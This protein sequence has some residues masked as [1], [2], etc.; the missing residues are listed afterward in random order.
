L[1]VNEAF[2]RKFLPGRDP[3]GAVVPFDRGR[4]VPVEKTIVGVVADAVYHSVRRIDE[5]TE[6]APLAQL[7]FPI[8][9]AVDAIISVRA[10][11]GSPLLLVRS[12][13]AA[14]G[15][16]SRDLVFAFRPLSEQ[17]VHR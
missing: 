9:P 14:L 11:N 5:P 1:I 8:P 10:A 4:G 13:A 7:D 16:A 2:V 12:I 3:I 17:S 6:Y 15:S